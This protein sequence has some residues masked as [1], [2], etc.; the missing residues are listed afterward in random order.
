MKIEL[1]WSI[2]VTETYRAV[3]EIDEEYGAR[4]R[5]L[6]AEGMDLLGALSR[7]EDETDSAFDL[8]SIA[9]ASETDEHEIRAD[10]H[11]RQIQRVRPL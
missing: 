2:E 8:E 1:T 5:E 10:V 3:V 6:L 9:A 7:I 11:E 4:L